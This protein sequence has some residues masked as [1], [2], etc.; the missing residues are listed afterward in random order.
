MK[1]ASILLLACG[2]TAPASAYTVTLGGGPVGEQPSTLASRD[3]SASEL[4]PRLESSSL[5]PGAAPSSLTSRATESDLTE[6]SAEE[7]LNELG[8]R[9]EGNRI[10]VSLPG[11]VLFDFDKDNIREDARPVL[12]QLAA[13]LQAMP[14]AP[15]QIIGHTDAKGSDDYN[16][17]LSERRAASVAVW[18]AELGIDEDRM[19]HDGHGETR[20]VAPN[21]H[22]DGSDDPEGRQKNRRVDFVIT[23]EE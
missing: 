13:A 14:D 21:Q 12:A 15:I 11:D 1:R 18:L 19:T 5:T 22:D 6:S 4:T 23:S 10:L 16:Q 9:R 2:L 8:A 3:L 7:S 20:P 17:D